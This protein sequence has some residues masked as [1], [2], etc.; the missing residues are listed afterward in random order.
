MKWLRAD[1]LSAIVFSVAAHAA[2]VAYVLPETVETRIAGGAEVAM[3]RIGDAFADAVMAGEEVGEAEAVDATEP[4]LEAVTEVAEAVEEAVQPVDGEAAEAVSSDVRS[5]QPLQAQAALTDSLSPVTVAEDVLKPVPEL[6]VS[7]PLPTAEK[8]PPAK[9]TATMPEAKPERPAD[10][11]RTPKAKEKTTP[12]EQ[13]ARKK[14]ASKKGSGGEQAANAR[15]SASGS[16]TAKQSS[17][18]GN[19]AVSNYP[20]KVY[21]RIARTRRKNAGGTGTARVSFSI[22]SGGG[23]ASVR[24]AKSSGN[25]RVDNAAVAHVKRAAPFPKPPAGAQRSFVIPIQF[26]R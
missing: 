23:L 19:G 3:M 13:P 24:L 22:S 26:K 4:P 9:N 6:P 11:E 5:S 2:I 1:Y 15:K 25:S 18:A 21:A 17:N 7:Q 10:K 16:K 12:K 20:G 14:A 8:K